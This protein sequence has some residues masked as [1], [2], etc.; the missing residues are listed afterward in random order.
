MLDRAVARNLC[1]QLQTQRR[2]PRVVGGAQVAQPQF[3]QRL[4]V[5]GR[6]RLRR[7][8]RE[9]NVAAMN[10]LS[11]PATPATIAV[12]EFAPAVTMPAKMMPNPMTIETKLA[13]K[14]A[15]PW[16]RLAA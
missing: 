3:D 2:R 10:W 5:C 1:E 4:R 8:Q 9:R 6:L 12:V 13:Q 14:I 16:L 11:T 7:A 15:C